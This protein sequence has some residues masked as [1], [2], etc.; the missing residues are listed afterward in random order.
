[1][2]CM[3]VGVCGATELP[4]S[5]QERKDTVEKLVTT[6][7]D[8]YVFPDRAKNVE[9]ALRKLHADGAYDSID[10]AEE[11]AVALSRDLQAASKD[12]HPRVMA[13]QV[14]QSTGK[15]LPDNQGERLARMRANNYG[16]TKVEHRPSNMGYLELTGFSP[17]QYSA[18]T[19]SAALAVL[20]HTDALIIDLRQNFGGDLAAAGFLASHFVDARTHLY[21]F[22]FRKGDR[23]EQRWTAEVLPSHHY[24][25]DKPVYILTSKDTFSAGEYFADVL[26][27]LNRATVV[28]E[29][30]GGGA[31]AGEVIRLTTRFTAFIPISRPVHP[32]TSSN[33]EGVGVTPDVRV[34]A[35][36]ALETTE[37]MIR[38]RQAP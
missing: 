3:L 18:A 10:N 1:M 14:R 15:P 6:F 19:L 26:Q 2:C 25:K 36:N 33:W 37:A 16:V 27:K 4:L 20:A 38:K 13:N 24:G 5:A 21:D 28:G 8:S 17:A 11:F 7:K 12:R 23:T 30:T 31:H 35:A 32:R 22:Y 29:T 34:P 9:S